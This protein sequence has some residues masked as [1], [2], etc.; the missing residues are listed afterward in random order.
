MRTRIEP[1]PALIFLVT[2][3]SGVFILALAWCFYRLLELPSIALGK[4]IIRTLPGPAPIE[5][6]SKP[7]IG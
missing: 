4:A 7:P 5:R 6:D 2:T 1:Y 3:A